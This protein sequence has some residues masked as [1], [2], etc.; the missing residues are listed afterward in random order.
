MHRRWP[1]ASSRLSGN[2][3]GAT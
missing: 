2:A 3:C 1:Q